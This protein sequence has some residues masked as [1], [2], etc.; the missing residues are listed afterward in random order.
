[1]FVE[2]NY[3][4]VYYFSEAR[5][6]EKFLD[7]RRAADSVVEVTKHGGVSLLGVRGRVELLLEV[8]FVVL[9]EE[10]LVD[11]LALR[12]EGGHKWGDILKDID[13][14]S[15]PS[16]ALREGL[17]DQTFTVGRIPGISLKALERYFI[18]K[19]GKK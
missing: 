18:T 5:L 17:A 10:A 8:E 11:A 14:M 1:M 2:N 19:P 16:Q 4:Y 7:L 3:I 12:V 13:L 15:A 9:A 6:C